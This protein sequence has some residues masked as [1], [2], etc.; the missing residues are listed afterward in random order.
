MFACIY[1]TLSGKTPTARLVRLQI[2]PNHSDFLYKTG[3]SVHFKIAVLRCDMPIDNIEIRYEIS[4]DMMKPHKTGTAR[5][6][7]GMADINGGTMK[8]EGFLRCRVFAQ[9]KGYDYSGTTPIILVYMAFSVL[10][11]HPENIRP[12]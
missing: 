8:K 1:T 2:T 10:L 6:K 9:Y 7:N 12:F 5:I 11:K 3:E 4:E